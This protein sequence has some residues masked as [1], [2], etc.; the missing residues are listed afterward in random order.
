[1]LSIN[2][3]IFSGSKFVTADVEDS[4]QQVIVWFVSNY[5]SLEEM[6]TIAS[7]TSKRGPNAE[8]HLAGL[9]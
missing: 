4:K 9:P 1:M 3:D 6:S 7:V 2:G 8:D 5:V